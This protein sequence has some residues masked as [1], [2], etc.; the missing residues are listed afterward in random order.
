MPRELHFVVAVSLLLAVPGAVS[1]PIGCGQNAV[2]DTKT[3]ET[4]YGNIQSQANPDFRKVVW[5]SWSADLPSK[6]QGLGFEGQQMAYLLSLFPLYTDM[7]D[8]LGTMG[9]YKLGMNC[10]QVAWL[11]QTATDDNGN[12][13]NILKV[14]ANTIIDIAMNNQTI[15]NVFPT[16]DYQANALALLTAAIPTSCVWGTVS[17]AKNVT[18]LI[19]VTGSMSVTFIDSWGRNMTKL[20]YVTEQ[21]TDTLTRNLLNVQNFNVI[22]FGFNAESW[23]P[24]LTPVTVDNVNRAAQWVL[25]SQPIGTNN[26]LAGLQAAIS[27]PGAEAIWILA[28]RFPDGATA[29]I[30]RVAQT[31]ENVAPYGELY[32]VG[33]LCDHLCDWMLQLANISRGVFRDN[34]V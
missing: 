26:M 27:D 17:V 2:L 15:I 6:M 4:L 13:I 3:F 31:W 29:D 22:R 33:F 19:S 32:P 21:M 24:R 12:R 14:V 5:S 9:P 25:A 11:L 34:E 7:V 20:H 10:S 28:D 18:F 16:P 23:A 30:I 8:I 1:Y